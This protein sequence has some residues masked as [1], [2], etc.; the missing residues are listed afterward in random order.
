MSLLLDTC[1]ISEM[2]KLKP[3]T[4]VADWF[5]KQK[6]DSLFISVLTLGELQKGI[7]KLEHSDRRTFLQKCIQD[8]VINAFEGR[9]LNVSGPIA[10]LWGE[11]VAKTEKIG[12]PM[13]YI[14]SLIAAT[15]ICHDLTFVTRNTKDVATSGVKLLNPWQESV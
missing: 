7:A 14:D 9:I 6:S 1:V 5:E 15:A 12:R 3:A 10:M 2:I 13:P 11:L 8:D 4:Q